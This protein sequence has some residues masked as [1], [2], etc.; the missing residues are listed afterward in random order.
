MAPYN[1]PL[2]THYTELDVSTYDEDFMWF[3][4]GQKGKN[5]YDIT[6]WLKIEYLWYN[7][8]RQVVEIWGSWKSLVERDAKSRVKMALESYSQIYVK[9]PTDTC[10]SPSDLSVDHQP[11]TQ[12][13]TPVSV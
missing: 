7:K 6:S 13:S 4:I 8:E 5:F 3:A 12:S 1:P 9:P 11:I 2:N 10:L